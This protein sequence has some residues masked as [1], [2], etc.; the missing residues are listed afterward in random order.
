MHADAL[1][2]VRRSLQRIGAVFCDC[3]VGQPL[4]LAR[5]AVQVDIATATVHSCEAVRVSGTNLNA[6][7]LDFWNS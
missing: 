1:C 6:C 4:Q 2:D 3:L 5:P 7:F